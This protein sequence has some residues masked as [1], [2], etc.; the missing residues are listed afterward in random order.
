MRAFWFGVLLVLLA[1]AGGAQEE[2]AGLVRGVD[3]QPVGDAQ[4]QLVYRE[5][6]D[7]W[8]P[9][10]PARRFA[11]L[12]TDAE[13][14]FRF[15]PEGTSISTQAAAA[16]AL[17]P[18]GVGRSAGVDE[19][20]VEPVTGLLLGWIVTIQPWQTASGIVTGP[21]GEPIEGAT[22]SLRQLEVDTVKLDGRR[23]RDI[24]ILADVTDDLP[25]LRP[26]SSANR[27][28]PWPVDWP[29]PAA[30]TGADGRWTIDR[31]PSQGAE[32]NVTAPGWTAARFEVPAG[33]GYVAEPVK[34]RPQ[35]GVRG[36]LLDDAGQ[37]LAGLHIKP[38]HYL[39]SNARAV[40]TDAEG[41][42]ELR[43]LTAGERQI[44]GE[45]LDSDWFVEPRTVTI[46]GGEVTEIGDLV[47]SRARPLVVSVT[48]GETGE[49]VPAVVITGL[50]GDM[51]FGLGETHRT[52]PDGRMV[53]RLP[54]SLRGRVYVSATP[55][56]GWLAANGESAAYQSVEL[57]DDAAPLTA[58]FALY[59]TRA[60]SGR[61][62]DEAGA[63]LAD[64][65]IRVGRRDALPLYTRS[66]ADGTFTFRALLARGSA[67]L[68]VRE[69]SNYQRYEAAIELADV[70]DTDW[71]LVVPV[72]ARAALRGRVVDAAGTPL[73]GASVSIDGTDPDL[74]VRATGQS[75]EDGTFVVDLPAGPLYS[76][77]AYK[78]GY[79]RSAPHHLAPGATDVGDIVL[80]GLFKKG[81]G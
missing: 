76:A 36:R 48:N 57:T 31:C 2:W 27:Q 8:P 20:I 55:S 37:P 52:G 79:G 45:S 61:L 14:R 21:D 16:L 38:G 12:A 11:P 23:A 30:T 53:L 74:P 29:V 59:P 18:E 70:P 22:V 81:N 78:D 72:V 1:S 9:P 58:T 71:Q 7:L 26:P 42:F 60:V 34:L 49:P 44:V 13:G 3:G 41:R 43:D 69:P 47:A 32:F 75:A 10:D 77:R 62:L 67:T 19:T 64:H 46:T 66:A 68:V 73:A 24:W 40:V 50:V 6:G 17:T 54:M 35:G 51:Q 39:S 5:V 80:P 63:P 56:G 25:P 28:L 15:K 65:Q 33:D 4:V